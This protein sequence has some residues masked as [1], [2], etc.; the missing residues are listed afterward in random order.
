[1]AKF[2]KGKIHP[3]FDYVRS[4]L[5]EMDV[6]HQTRQTKGGWPY[7]TFKHPTSNEVISFQFRLP[8]G[9][10]PPRLVVFKPG[11]AYGDQIKLYFNTMSEFLVFL[12]LSQD[13][14]E[15]L[16][17]EQLSTQEDKSMNHN[18]WN[19][20][21]DVGIR[22]GGYYWRADAIDDSTIYVV[23]VTPLSD[24]GGPDNQ[25]RIETGQVDLS[26]EDHLT[27]AREACGVDPKMADLNTD[28]D[29]MI[30]AFGLSDYDESFVL[31]IGP[32]DEF[33]DGRGKKSDPSH[34]LPEDSSLRDWI[35]AEYLHPEPEQKPSM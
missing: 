3:P 34:T 29:A 21:G 5:T 2:D 8:K 20:N 13:K 6:M 35:K 18:G 25:F 12:G 19:Y 14:I 27:R 11:K 15:E 28:V 31:Q 22:H 23:R 16:R 24:T 1:M 30:S 26:L 33:W 10:L 4:V 7:L 9:E 17:Q 32:D